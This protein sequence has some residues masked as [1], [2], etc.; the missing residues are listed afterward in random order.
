MGSRPGLLARTHGAPL[1]VFGLGVGPLND[2]PAKRYL[3]FLGE[4]CASITVRDVESSAILEGIDGWSPEVE[5]RPDP[6]Y[7]VD[8]SDPR[9]PD[10]LGSQCNG[11]PILLVDLTVEL[12]DHPNRSTAPTVRPRFVPLLQPNRHE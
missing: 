8:L 4:E 1:H 9:T 6:V 3:R 5:V 12:L 2:E 11:L 7:A 10:E